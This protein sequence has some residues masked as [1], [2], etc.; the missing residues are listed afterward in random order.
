MCRN[1]KTLFN[2][3]P[4]VTK[5]EIVAASEQYVRKV[6]GF[7]QPSDINQDAFELAVNEV[8]TATHKLMHSLKTTAKPHDREEEAKKAHQRALK[9]FGIDS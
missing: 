1:I 7:A 8:A 3:D 4:P 5:D 2:F 9:R 6:S